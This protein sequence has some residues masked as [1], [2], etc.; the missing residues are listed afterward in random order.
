MRRPQ[1]AGGFIRYR[2]V[3]VLWGTATS[4]AGARTLAGG[5]PGLGR[6]VA[7]S[8]REQENKT[9][10]SGGNRSARFQVRFLTI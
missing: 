5:G 8:K 2:F 4:Q 9:A 1:A 6:R 10:L 3:R 7:R